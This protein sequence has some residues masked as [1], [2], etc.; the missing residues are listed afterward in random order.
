VGVAD[1]LLASSGSIPKF[2]S[3]RGTSRCELRN[4]TTTSN[5]I[6]LAPLLKPDVRD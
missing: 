1:R 5:S 3:A 6:I 2:A 4:L